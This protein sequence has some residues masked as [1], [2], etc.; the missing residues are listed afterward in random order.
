MSLQTLFI[1]GSDSGLQLN[2]KPFLIP[3]KAFSRLEN[4][5]AWRDR[6]KKREGLAELGR[7][8]RSLTTESIGNI[9]SP[10]AG[11]V[12]VNIPTAL[13]IIATE[14]DAEI[15]PGDITNISIVIA[16]PI[17]QTLADTT[18][19][20]NLT[21]SGAGSSIT[22][23]ILN[24]ATGDLIL[25]FS[26]AAGASAA[27]FT[28]AYYPSLPVMGIPTRD[29]STI[30]N[31]QTIWFDTKYAYIFSAGVFQEFIT[32][33]TWQST[34]SDFFWGYNYRG[35][36]AS[37]RLLFVTNFISDANNPMR[38]TDGTTWT[39]FAPL[40]TATDTIFSAKV[41]VAYYGRLLLLNTWEGTTGGG[42]GAATNFF[43]RVRVSQLGDP[44]A[45]DAFRVD[46]FGKGFSIDVPTN[47]AIISATFFKNT[48][49]VQTERATWQLRYVGDYGVP[50]IF[51]RISSDFGCESQFSAVLFDQGVAAVGDR[52]IVSATGTN[53]QRIDEQIPDIVFNFRNSNAGT[54]R[55]H[56]IRD[57]QRELVFWNYVDSNQVAS[58]QVFPNKVLLFNYK[59]S[60]Y[61]IFRDNVT[62]FGIFQPP[63]D[64]V[65]WDATDI[66]WDDEEVYWDD[67]DN[68]ALFPR[69]VIGNQQGYVHYYGYTSEYDPSLS[70]TAITRNASPLSNPLQL[71]IDNHNLST[72]EIIYLTGITFIDTSTGDPVATDLNEEIYQVTFIDE[73]TV[74]LLKWDGDNYATFSYTPAFGTG[75]YIGKGEVTLLPK[76]NMT[77]KDFNPWQEMGNEMF[78]SS[79]SFLTDNVPNGQFTVELYGNS[80]LVE[81]MNL[82]TGNQ[83]LETSLPSP[84]YF[85][86]SEYAWHRFYATASAQYIRLTLTY[87][88]D[89]MNDITTHRQS[90]VLNAM[91]IFA[92][93]AGKLP[94]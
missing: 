23:A 63:G 17:D 87:D 39:T 47:E 59:N 44:T 14:P 65:S 69:I 92:R 25:T 43:N 35:S 41:I 75:T 42:A 79:V 55:V 30:N 18:G 89:L 37:T 51:E 62:A 67:P 71:T 82:L 83:E 29:L 38:Y 49:I 13:S 6:T 22:L 45:A 40:Y 77:T 57:F 73:D 33:T 48:L 64:V 36:A 28:G 9:S 32:G 53:V 84:F 86:G 58:N 80:S 76:M 3:E 88:D 21:I 19:T 74:S 81:K 93:K 94:F 66:F 31:E 4:S 52:A 11:T 54:Q 2:K 1:A 10:G 34:N 12:T 27:T 15:E 20:G 68:Q 16:A 70:I 56:G 61:G 60:T 90:F 46:Q 78:L 8:R 85:P 7:L 24:Y 5:Y 91:A 50:F 72:G 26:G